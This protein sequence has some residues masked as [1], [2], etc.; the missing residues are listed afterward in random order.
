MDEDWLCIQKSTSENQKLRVFYDYLVDQ[1]LGNDYMSRETWNYWW[2]GDTGN[3]SESCSQWI[4]GFIS[5]PYF[6]LLY[7]TVSK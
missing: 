4:N 1:C 3:I 7:R 5:E 6:Y 2:Q